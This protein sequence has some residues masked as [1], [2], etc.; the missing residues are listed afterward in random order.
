MSVV[1]RQG[2]V[3]T[4]GADVIA[5]Q[6]NCFGVMGAGVAKQI[7]TKY[8]KVYAEYKKICD[9]NQNNI[10][11]LGLSHWV[12]IGERQWIANLFGQ[13]GYGRGDVYTVYPALKTALLRTV[14]GCEELEEQVVHTVRLA[15][16]YK[17]GC[18][19]AG[20]DWRVVLP[21]I[22]KISEDTDVQLEIWKL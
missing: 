6:V 17:I 12:P 4:S 10:G 1:E 20:G 16:P 15:L 18:G 14:R 7:R 11:L 8:P 3:L 21:M 5:H 9:D 22:Q 2:D 19:L 13:H